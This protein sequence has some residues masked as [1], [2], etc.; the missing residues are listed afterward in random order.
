MQLCT[1]SNRGIVIRVIGIGCMGMSVFYGASDDGA[2]RTALERAAE[3]GVTL[4][5]GTALS[6]C[7]RGG[8]WVCGYP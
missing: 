3:L 6:G 5:G 1:S 4:F 2:S 8:R 7:A